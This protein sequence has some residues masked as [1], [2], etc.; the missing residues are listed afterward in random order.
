MLKPEAIQDLV[1]KAFILEAIAD[2]RDCTSRYN[3][4]P[5]KTLEDFI[6]AG[7]NAGPFFAKVAREQTSGSL[8]IY[9]YL[10]PAL[11][12]SNVHK[13]HKYI[14]KGLL[15]IMFNVVAARLSQNDPEKVVMEINRLLSKAPKSDS[16]ALVAIRREGW[17]TS[18]NPQKLAILDL[19]QLL[20]SR[21]P[22]EYNET[23]YSLLDHDSASWQWGNEAH[24]DWPLLQIIFENLIQSNNKSLLD[25]ISGAFN[26]VLADYPKIRIGI[27]AD[28]CA[29]AIFLYLSFL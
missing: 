26:P 12:A 14:N 19:P 18:T 22:F 8:E 7:I 4:L 5:G 20:A 21:S 11:K 3:D 16:E 27:L 9:K 24:R 15:E 10:L 23:L 1:T 29:A 25:K 13:S 2:K 6:M 28:M 17:S